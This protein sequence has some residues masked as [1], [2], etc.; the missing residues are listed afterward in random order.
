M[1]TDNRPGLGGGDIC[2]PRPPLTFSRPTVPST[3]ISVLAKRSQPPWE[4]GH[5]QSGNELSLGLGGSDPVTQ[6]SFT[7]LKWVEI[8]FMVHV[9]CTQA[10]LL[11]PSPR[12][13]DVP[14]TDEE[15]SKGL[16]PC[17][18]VSAWLTAPNHGDCKS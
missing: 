3:S 15:T 5:R 12:E 17:L 8:T 7:S 13:E 18:L 14:P 1:D 11:Y 16:C 9:L 10:L 2:S 4:R 6:F